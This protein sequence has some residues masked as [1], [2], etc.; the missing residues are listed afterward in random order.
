MPLIEVNNAV[1]GGLLLLAPKTIDANDAIRQGS[2]SIS[3]ICC[4]FVYNI[5]VDQVEFEPQRARMCCYNRQQ[6]VC[7]AMCFQ[8]RPTLVSGDYTRRAARYGR[9]CMRQ[10]RAVHRR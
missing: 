8:Y 10:R 6:S 7:V 3:S 4:V 2:I 1:D 5:Y 9:F